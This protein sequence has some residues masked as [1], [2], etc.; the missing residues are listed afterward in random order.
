MVLVQMEPLQPPASH[1]HSLPLG[2]L[3]QASQWTVSLAAAFSADV[4][5]LEPRCT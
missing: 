4:V 3:K 1:K 5:T 2:R